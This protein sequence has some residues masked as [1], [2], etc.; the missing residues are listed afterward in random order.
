MASSSDS[1]Q[2]SVSMLP[3]ET[4]YR[5]ISIRT[6]P[7]GKCYTLSSPLR[8]GQSVFARFFQLPSR[9][10]IFAGVSK[11]VFFEIGPVYTLRNRQRSGQGKLDW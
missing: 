3:Y 4:R 8:A 7:P 1:A 10:V 9:I 11:M 6:L 2:T 5:F